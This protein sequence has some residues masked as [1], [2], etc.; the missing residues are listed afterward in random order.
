MTDEQRGTE[1]LGEPIEDLE[2]P[3]VTQADVTGGATLCDP[4]TCQGDSTVSVFCKN[5]GGGPETCRVSTKTCS[6]Q[7]A[8]VV[9]SEY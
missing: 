2:A 5:P 3:A 6:L 8:A 1:G 9:V 4:P 7:T